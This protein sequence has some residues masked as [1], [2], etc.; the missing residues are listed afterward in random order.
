MVRLGFAPIQL[1]FLSLGRVLL[2]SRG[3]TRL[4]SF[5]L[6]SQRVQYTR[7]PSRSLSGSFPTRMRAD[8]WVE[9]SVL[10]SGSPLASL[11]TDLR[12]PYYNDDF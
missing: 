7:P 3:C 1:I 4:C 2:T 12:V 10:H 8:S 5:L 9:F 6:H 11:S